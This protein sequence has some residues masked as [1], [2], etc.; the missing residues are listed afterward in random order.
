MFIDRNADRQKLPVVLLSGSL[1]SGKTTLINAALRDPRM[2]DTAVAIN[3]FGEVPIDHHLIDHGG[4]RTFVMANGCLC[5][6]LAGDMEDAV[7]RVFS[8]RQGGELPAFKRLI[9]EPSGLADPA[10]IAQAILRNPVMS[11]AMRL[12]AIV[13]TVDAV[14]A[15]TQLAR[16][17]EGRNQVSLADRLV[18]TKTDLADRAE[19]AK[20]KSILAG[21]NPLAPVLEA[22]NGLVDIDALFPASFIDPDAP[23]HSILARDLFAT[24]KAHGDTE[25]HGH[26]MNNV[27][28][29]SLV[30]DTPL[31]WRA[32]DTWLRGV[33]IAHSEN[34]LRIKGIL[35]IAGA[36]RPVV[37]QGVHHVI[38]PPVELE[39]WPDQDR[40]SRVVAIV[41]G[42]DPGV[43]QASWNAALPSMRAASAQAA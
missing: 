1:G 10:P 6:N 43:I 38:H 5:C 3:E 17:D 4:D 34:L 24:R 26:T 7:M 18:L 32:F 35:D 2:A 41:R 20:L 22:S 29:V 9:V 12:E 30:S 31:D 37:I 21:L 28:A 23:G 11:R 33:R 40:R 13:T 19:T 15:E 14:F 42:L 25:R 16:H 8:R 27:R 36:V 39:S